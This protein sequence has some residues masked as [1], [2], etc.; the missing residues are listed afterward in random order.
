M[1]KASERITKKDLFRA[2]LNWI[3]FNHA[4]YN[5]EVM[6]G[7]AVCLSFLPLANKLYGPGE[8]EKKKEA[9]LRQMMFFN[10]EVTLGSTVIGLAHTMEAQIANDEGIDPEA[11]VSLKAGLMGPIAGIGDTLQQGVVLPLLISIAISLTL[12]SNPFFGPILVIVVMHLYQLVPPWF[13][14]KFAYN[15]GSD[16]ILNMLESGVLNKFIDAASIVGCTVMG[17]L[18]A[19]YVKLS[20][21]VQIH[22]AYSDFDLQ[23]GFFD[24]VLP[25]M[26]PLALTMGCMALMKKGWKTGKIIW[27][28]FGIGLIGGAIG[29]F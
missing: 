17:A 12:E 22:T 4:C 3:V 8:E 29:I 9:L 7:L 20:L 21:N 24:A 16:A 19:S 25:C 26:L 15:K 6:Q 5:Y 28:L 10:T 23:T 13:L 1:E 11:V 2:W 14:Y 27:L 18:I